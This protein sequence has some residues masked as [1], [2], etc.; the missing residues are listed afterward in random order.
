M[1]TK[2]TTP[3]PEADA[4]LTQSPQTEKKPTGRPSKYRV[5]LATEICE[6]LSEGEP[7]RQICRDDHMPAWRTI[8][9]W[10]KKDD[11]LG[12][13]SVGLSAAIACARD[14]GYDKMAEECLEI[15]DDGSN[16]WMEK[17]D[18]NGQPVGWLLNGDHVQRSKLRIE[19][20]LK[21]LAKFNPKRYGDKVLVGGDP[22]AAPVQV[23]VK[24]FFDSLLQNIELN[25]Q[26][27]AND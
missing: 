5:E 3:K 27:V 10:M 17:L 14:V 1:A 13:A 15:A 20:R 11:S 8:Y 6:R 19:T 12:D 22:D 26:K 7:L 23:D 24:S 2:K 21:L 9:D 18:K 25:K 16:D 4:E